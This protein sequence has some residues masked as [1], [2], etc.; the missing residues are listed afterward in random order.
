VK[1]NGI[2]KVHKKNNNPVQFKN[3]KV[4]AP[5]DS[6]P[7]NAELQFFYA[8]QLKDTRLAPKCTKSGDG[9]IKVENNNLIGII[10]SWG[11]TFKISF[12]LKVLSFSTCNP[13]E[14]ANYLTFTATDLNCCGIGDRIPAFFTNRGGFLQVATQIN[15]NENV[16]KSSPKLEENVWYKLEVEQLIQNNQ[17][18]FVLRASGKEVFRELQNQPLHYTNVKV[19]ASKYSPAN[20][21]IRNLAYN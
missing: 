9:E 2:R 5:D 1:I 13:M 15:N 10:P 18:F 12:E 8:C 11:P 21:V 6:N 19:Y 16:I 20:A 3:V 7:A 4:F 17:F 14:M